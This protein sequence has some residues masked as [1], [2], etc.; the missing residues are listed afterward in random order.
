MFPKQSFQS[1]SSEDVSDLI[2]SVVSF[3]IIL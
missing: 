3:N 1:S 2:I